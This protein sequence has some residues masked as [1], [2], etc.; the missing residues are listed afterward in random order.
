MQNH[1]TLITTIITMVLSNSKRIIEV[2]LD[3]M[4]SYWRANHVDDWGYEIREYFVP[5]DSP[6][7]LARPVAQ[8]SILCGRGSN[9]VIIAREEMYGN[10]ASLEDVYSHLLFMI[11]TAGVV[12]DY[13]DTISMYRSGSV[14]MYSATDWNSIP[15]TPSECFKKS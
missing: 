11:A 4:Q 8:V 10:D 2:A 1:Y 5:V 9:K 13:Q 12:K 3:R 15:L 14:P 6:E 7:P